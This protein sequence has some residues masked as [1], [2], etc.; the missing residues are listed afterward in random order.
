ML[1]FF[2]SALQKRTRRRQQAIKAR[3]SGNR[4]TLPRAIGPNPLMITVPF[5]RHLFAAALFILIRQSQP[6]LGQE[7]PA[8]SR[9]IE[10]RAVDPSIVIDLRYAGSN[11]VLH[12][13]LYPPGTPAVLRENVAH[14][15]AAAQ[16][17]LRGQRGSYRLKIWDAYRPQRVQDELWRATK[18]NS[19]VADPADGIGSLHTRGAAVDATLVDSS[20]RDVPMPTDFDSFTPAALLFYQ[21]SNATVRAHLNA[22]QQAMAHAG[23]YGM[24]T[25][26]WHFCAPD[27]ASYP[28]MPEIEFVVNGKPTSR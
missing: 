4:S 9:F 19:Y 12:R 23:F 25:E 26:W 8:G 10:I 18:N 28:L 2:F 22:L 17:Y 15:L 3:L 7:L 24:R 21:G 11:N 5:S 6:A 20:G 14:R 27:W 13:P 1:D 16:K